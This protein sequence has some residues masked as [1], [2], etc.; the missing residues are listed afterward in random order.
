VKKN[1]SHL[2][3]FVIFGANGEPATGVG[4]GGVGGE[5]PVCPARGQ[6]GPLL[7]L[8]LGWFK[9]LTVRGGCCASGKRVASFD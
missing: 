4:L 8:G 9:N 5:A 6:K 3:T 1:K 7:L 2:F